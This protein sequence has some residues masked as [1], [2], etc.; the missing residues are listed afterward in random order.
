[1]HDLMIGLIFLAIVAIPAIVAS[2]PRKDPE[3]GA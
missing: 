1:M 2:M 3:D